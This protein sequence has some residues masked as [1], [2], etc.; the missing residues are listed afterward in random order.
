MMQKKQFPIDVRKFV[1][2]NITLYTGD[3]SFL[4]WPSDK[5][6]K[7]REI[8]KKYLKEERNN[9]GCRSI[10]TETISNITSHKA[11]YIDADL[12]TIVGL[13]TDEPLR[14]AMKPFGWIRVVQWA[15]KERWLEVAPRVVDIFNYAK[16]H[17]DAV[18]S[19]YDDEIKKFRSKHIVTG[20]PD[21]YAR[22]RIIWDYRR[23][24]LYGI[25]YI[26]NSK[27][28]DKN[29]IDGELTEEK[30]RMREELSMQISALTDIKVMAWYYG[31]DIS[32]PAKS[33]KEAIQRVYFAYLSAIKEQDGA[34][35]SLGNVSSFLDI[36]IEQ[37][38]QSGKITESKAQ[39]M[40]DHFVMKLRLVRHLRPGAYDDIFGWDPTRVTESIWWQ[41]P[42]GR[43][44]VTKTS[45]RFL[46]T[47]YNLW[48]SPEPNLT[49]LRSQDL[50]QGFKD[51]C[52]KVSID[53]SSVQYEN[54]DLMRDCRGSED[55]GI[56]CCV[57]YQE[58]G[59]R[60][61][62][63]WARCNL[64]KTLLLAIN[65]W[66]EEHSGEKILSDINGLSDWI[67]KYDEVMSNFKKTMSEV[68][69][70]YA[71]SMFAIHY[72]HDKYYYEKAQMAFVDTD[73]GIDIAYGIAGI[74]IIAD[75][76]SAIKYAK[77]KA[78]RDENGIA[79]DFEITWEFP[80]Y[81]NDDDRVDNIAKEVS[82]YFFSEL[83]KHK[84]YKK[85]NPTMSILTI[86]SNV[87]YGN[88][89]GSTPDGR[90]AGE[91]FA[92]GANPMHGRDDH[93]AIASLN[94]V[95]KLWYEFAQD[96]ISNTFSIVPS[97]LWSD[98]EEQVA[99]LVDLMNGYFNQKAHH[100]N[101]NVLNREVLMDAYEHPE[102]Y[103]Q[104]TI[105]VSGYAV[106]FPRLS[107]AHQLEVIARTFHKSM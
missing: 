105:R 34:A 4:V 28:E 73:H 78:I 53:T 102:N 99:N 63:F 42:D 100:L 81:W 15:V 86:T 106:I 85:A 56:A 80:K 31:F 64:P 55:Y 88:N 74:S 69:R 11:G 46:Q 61:Q 91:A 62:H 30:V 79:K 3:A 67:L 96:G 97:A 70:I 107:K 16:N 7:L 43:T 49:V 17:N 40:I 33:S 77:V 19:V 54:D 1:S 41:F 84:P 66:A 90:K 72:M 60:I 51:F 10:D 22:W 59:K 52:A 27:K 21:N 65:A 45:F 9:N 87:M 82:E 75:S 18:F 50:P 93:G 2:D 6:T 92:P 25:D 24:A 83:K 71:K 47:L 48:P 36:F 38:L 26:I 101:V 20:L 95:A 14:R 76:L 5:T 103:P 8:C 58:I 37:D 13:Q 98:E 94:S 89:T 44:K 68:A 12:E 23:L 39:E 32:G 57:S 35:M 104:L 29:M